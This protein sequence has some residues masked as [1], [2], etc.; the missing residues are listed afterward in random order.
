[1]TSQEIL[2]IYESVAD[3]TDRM[4]AAA[5]EGDWEKLAAL[6]S[7]CSS[8]V[9]ILRRN[10]AP[11]QPLSEEARAQKAKIIRKILADDREIRSITEP[12]MT[13]LAAMINSAGTERKLSR[14][15][16]PGR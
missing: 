13:Q 12:W 7:D 9:D 5:R 8:R 14:A 4:L 1:M 2:T 16:D 3:I 15:Y 11:R 10:D 6:E